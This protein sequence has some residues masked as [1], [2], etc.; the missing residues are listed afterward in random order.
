MSCYNFELI[1]LDEGYLDDSV[2]ATYIIHLEGN[3]ERL[4]NIHL[5]LHKYHVTKLNYIVVNKGYKKCDKDLPQQVP[6]VD[7]IDAFLTVFKD[8]KE[9][10]YNNI[11]VLEDDF[12][13]DKCIKD[14]KIHNEINT[15]LNKNKDKEVM[16]YLGCIPY[17]QIPLSTHNRLLLSTGTHA[18]IYTKPLYEKILKDDIYSH[19]SSLMNPD[20]DYYCNR[21]I[22]RY[23]YYT[24]LCYQLFPN[25]QNS[26]HWEKNFFNFG[27]VIK[28][29]LDGLLLNTQVYPGYNYCYLISKLQ[30]FIVI[31]LL[32]VILINVIY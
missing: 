13:Y 17:L 20:W 23:T 15:F 29:M 32:C 25:T 10:K 11:L 18:C 6:A 30:L 19:F 16:Y 9:K 27:V 3:K 8:A 4:Q 1:E 5:Q 2:D 28:Y 31:L 26:K 14:P 7:L 12:F 22:V 21:Y 24:P